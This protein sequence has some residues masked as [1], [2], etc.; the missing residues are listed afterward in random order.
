MKPGISD[1]QFGRLIAAAAVLTLVSSLARADF[2]ATASISGLSFSATQLDTGTPGTPGVSYAFVDPAGNYPAYYLD[3]TDSAAA[4]WGVNLKQNALP[5]PASGVSP[6]SALADSVSIDNASSI[7]WGNSTSI[8]GMAAANGESGLRIAGLAASFGENYAAADN[9]YNVL[10][11][12]PHTSLTIGF[13]MSMLLHQGGQC[14]AAGECDAAF[15][16]IIVQYNAIP[17]STGYS[18][19]GSWVLSGPTGGGISAAPIV[20]EPYASFVAADVTNY[21]Q[22]EHHDFLLTNATDAA[23]TYNFYGVIYADGMSVAAVPEPGSYAMLLAGLGMIAAVARR[24]RK[25]RQA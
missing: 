10:S 12:A 13:D 2:S 24:R 22:T 17:D 1:F 6:L 23:V 14:N 7:L 8:T 19:S 21:E 4:A 11:I 5:L 15:A 20:H 16:E 25:N 9:Y 18:D 3:V